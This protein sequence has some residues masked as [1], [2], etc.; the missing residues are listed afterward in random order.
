MEPG[1]YTQPLIRKHFVQ[2]P[3]ISGYTTARLQAEDWML[4]PVISGAGTT[5]SGTLTANNMLLTY[6]NT[7]GTTFSV[8]LQQTADR[9]ISGVRTPVTNSLTLV[10]GGTMQQQAANVLQAYLEVWCNGSGPG[11]LRLQIESQRQWRELG[12]DKVADAT[13]YPTSLWQATEYPG[14]VSNT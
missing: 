1:L 12:F 6:E 7:G 9:S 5:Y 14:P 3:M 4:P 13:F 8:I 11:N 10:P 2:C